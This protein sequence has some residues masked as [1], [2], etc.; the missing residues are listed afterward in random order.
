MV[1]I[2]GNGSA[3]QPPYTFYC[4]PTQRYDVRVFPP[5]CI[6]CPGVLSNRMQVARIGTSVHVLARRSPQKF[7]PG[8]PQNKTCGCWRT[9]ANQ[10]VAFDVVLNASWVVTGLAFNG[11]VRQRWLREVE[12]QAS[13]DNATFLPWGTYTMAN[14][15]P[16]ASLAVFAFPIRARLFRVTV[17][18]YANHDVNASSGFR[19]APVH[20]LVSQDQPFGC[21]CP[22]L[23]SGE[24]CPYNNMTVRGDRCEWCMDPADI[25]TRMADGSC[26]KCKPGTFEHKGRCYPLRP[27]PAASNTLA[28]G[29]PWSNGVEWRFRVN[30]T[31]DA[32]SM[33]LLF[34]MTSAASG[35]AAAPPPPPPCMRQGGPPTFWGRATKFESACCLREYYRD[36]P[37]PW[38]PPIIRPASSSSSSSSSSSTLTSPAAAAT[39]PPSAPTAPNQEEEEEA[40]PDDG[41]TTAGMTAE[42]DPDDGTADTTMA[43]QATPTVDATP[44][45]SSP[46]GA[47]QDGGDA[48][49]RGQTEWWRWTPYIPILWNFTPPLEEDGEA[50][51]DAPPPDQERCS[52]GPKTDPPSV[53]PAWTTARQSVQFDRGRGSVVLSFTQ[54]EI[55]AWTGCGAD[56]TV[57]TATIG[58][59]YLTSPTAPPVTAFLPQLTVR[60]LRFDFAVPPL[61]CPTRRALPSPLTRAEVHYYAATDTYTV[62]LIGGAGLSGAII[63]FRWGEG[64]DGQAEEGGGWTP[65]PNSPEP[66]LSAPPYLPSGGGA[67]G[68]GGGEAET[69]PPLHLALPT[70]RLTDGVNTLRI[71]PPIRPVVHGA[72]MR[73]TLSGILVEVAYGFGFA[74]APSF[75]DTEQVVIVTA[76]STQP[77]RLRRLATS[78]G[79]E[80]TVYTTARGFIADTRRVLDLGVACYNQDRAA[81]VRWLLQGIQLLDTPGLPHAEFI[82]RSCRMV[83]SGEVAKA[84]WLV[85]WRGNL[86]PVDRRAQGVLEVVAEFA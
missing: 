53:A 29:S 25:Q 61:V 45:P 20:A 66:V 85:P 76:R 1:R 26:A 11:N 78:Q 31:T 59:L 74:R 68:S 44:A 35:A 12:I 54:R 6:D 75:G 42:E 62:R 58:A 60:P 71:E 23:P 77:A 8:L 43:P 27:E 30:Y 15:T 73:T 17:R 32:H 57:C 33:V 41:S 63:R 72:V 18:R 13:D 83:L 16:A 21:A 4:P 37:L 40:D 69:A 24:C 67:G 22:M 49:A 70:L 10:T 9:P 36:H 81:M 46:P 50:A 64:D 55:R 48:E 84:Y 56:A 79:G 47:E 51:P 28:V 52:V 82:Q 80:T 65:T 34:M 19:I 7:S 38:P 14:F 3:P 86:L 39:P 2:A 5:R